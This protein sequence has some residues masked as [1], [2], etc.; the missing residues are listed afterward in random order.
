MER[1]N[2]SLSVNYSISIL[3]IIRK[4]YKN[5]PENW[6]INSVIEQYIIIVYGFWKIRGLKSNENKFNIDSMPLLSAYAM[7]TIEIWHINHT[8]NIIYFSCIQQNYTLKIP[9]AS[10]KH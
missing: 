4:Q 5:C 3:L 9:Q 7:G 10:R 1:D 2:L 6:N 8:K